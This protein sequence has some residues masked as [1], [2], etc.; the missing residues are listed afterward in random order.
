MEMKTSG[1]VFQRIMD[2]MLG[3][4]QPKCAVTYINDITIFSPNMEQHL[5]DMEKVFKCLDRV[6]LKV[7]VEKFK[8]AIS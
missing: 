5:I 6:N 1:A 2:D 4:L 7:N 3:D 8:F